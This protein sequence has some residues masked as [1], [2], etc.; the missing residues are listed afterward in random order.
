MFFRSTGGV[1]CIN[2]LLLLDSNTDGCPTLFSPHMLKYMWAAYTFG[3]LWKNIHAQVL[4]KPEPLLLWDNCPGEQMPSH[5]LVTCPVFSGNY[6][7]FPERFYYFTFPLAMNI[8]VTLFSISSL[9]WSCYCFFV[10]AVL[11]TH[12]GFN[13]D[14]IIYLFLTVFWLIF[15]LDCFFTVEF[16]EFF[17]YSRYESFFKYSLSTCSF[18]AQ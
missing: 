12:C 10:P 17:I 9:T 1:E 2:S 6:Q 5:I 13:L 16:W 3:L 4:C 11:T 7:T 15:Y 8:W 18:F 14:L